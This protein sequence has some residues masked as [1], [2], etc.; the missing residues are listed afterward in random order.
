MLAIHAVYIFDLDQSAPLLTLL[1][2][3]CSSLEQLGKLATQNR[4]LQILS[5]H[6]PIQVS[7]NV[8]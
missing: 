1:S 6:I 8:A 3:Y 2:K 7:G 5:R 4:S